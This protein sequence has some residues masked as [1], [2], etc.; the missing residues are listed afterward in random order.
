MRDTLIE[1]I[2]SDAAALEIK[3]SPQEIATYLS[4]KKVS[5]EQLDVIQ[6]FMAYLRQNKQEK[7][8]AALLSHSRIPQKE[9]ST[10]ENF[11]FSRVTGENAAQIKKSSESYC[12]L[13]QAESCIHRTSR[14][15]KDS[16][17]YGIWE[18]VLSKWTENLLY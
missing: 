12:T 6:H 18:C 15:W 14:S 1:Q 3:I 2:H 5:P 7:A 11:D 8:I 9:P 4:E 16:S 13:F 17:F 10:F